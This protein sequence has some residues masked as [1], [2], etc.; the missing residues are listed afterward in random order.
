MKLLKKGFVLT[1]VVKLLREKVN[2]ELS[3]DAV[4]IRI[5]DL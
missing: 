4:I 2:M 3:L 5:A 1:V